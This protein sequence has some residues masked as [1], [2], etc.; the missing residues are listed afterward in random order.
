MATDLEESAVDLEEA[1]IPTGTVAAPAEPTIGET[2][3]TP[4]AAPAK[5]KG[6]T[7]AEKAQA[8]LDSALDDIRKKWDPRIQS[9]QKDDFEDDEPAA[10]EPAGGAAADAGG[11]GVA[12]DDAEPE[13]AADL[14]VRQQLVKQY[15]LQ[16]VEQL[17]N[18]TSAR[19][20]AEAL[21]LQD[22]Q[23]F[24]SLLSKPQGQQQQPPA[25]KPAEQLTPEQQALKN[26]GL[27]YSEWDEKEPLRQNL[28]KVEQAILERD[29][30][31]GKLAERLQ[32]VEDANDSRE[33]AQRSQLFHQT[34]DS[35]DPEQFGSSGK[36]SP[37][38][39]LL[40]QKFEELVG[41]FGDRYKSEYGE[42]PRDIPGFTQRVARAYGFGIQPANKQPAAKTQ[43]PAPAAT[44]PRAQLGPP[45][46]GTPRAKSSSRKASDFQGDPR[47]NPVLHELFDEL[48][49][50]SLVG[51]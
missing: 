32:A 12:A 51:E 38:Q 46:R 44:P 8:K 28:S 36:L 7:R 27:D 29:A 13:A 2:I 17:A 21:A 18:F 22:R 31:I 20:A 34:L 42:Y 50:R 43:P 37:A 25:T 3:A 45:G 14:A 11:E 10:D 48:A 30:V 40:R 41:E 15:G 47:D 19:D 49:E 9:A 35:I 6:P 26:L 1:A 24:D 4:A 39:T 23:F 5:E 33:T 16:S